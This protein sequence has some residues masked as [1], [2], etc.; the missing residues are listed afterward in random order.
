[1]ERGTKEGTLVIMVLTVIDILTGVAIDFE[2][3]PK[4][5]QHF[6]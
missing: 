4:Y 2:I 5:C 3:I 1:M 6:P